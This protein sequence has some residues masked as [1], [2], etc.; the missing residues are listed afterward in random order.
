M[1]WT[2]ISS[3]VIMSKKKFQNRFEQDTYSFLFYVDAV[4]LQISR[5]YT[6]STCDTDPGSYKFSFFF[7]IKIVPKNCLYETP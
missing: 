2:K 3:I 7:F 6:T 4:L 5:L 1:N